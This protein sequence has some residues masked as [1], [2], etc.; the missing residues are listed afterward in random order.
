MGAIVAII[1]LELAPV[2]MSMSGL[3]GN[4]DLGMSHSQAIFISMFSLVVTLL[5]TVVFRGFLAVI[6]VLIG[7]VSGYILSA[8]MALLISLL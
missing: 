8:F 6:P 1:G 2:A 3:I 7:V 5:G 4:Q